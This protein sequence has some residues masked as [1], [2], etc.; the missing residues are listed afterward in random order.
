MLVRNFSLR[1]K[2]PAYTVTAPSLLAVG[3]NIH[4]LL[5]EKPALPSFLLHTVEAVS[6]THHAR[7]MLL[8]AA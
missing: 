2:F 6:R 4:L 5:Q 3:Q 8:F 1:L 7:A